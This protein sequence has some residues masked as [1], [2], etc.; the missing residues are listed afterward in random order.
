MTYRILPRVRVSRAI[1]RGRDGREPCGCFP[2]GS[3]L[4]AVRSAAP[5]THGRGENHKSPDLSQYC[6]VIKRQISSHHNSCF[7]RSGPLASRWIRI[8]LRAKK[9][10]AAVAVVLSKVPRRSPRCPFRRASPYYLPPSQAM[11]SSRP[12]G[13]RFSEY[14]P[15]DH[16][17]PLWIA[18]SITL[19]YAGLFLIVRLAVKWRLWSL[20]DVFLGVAHV[21]SAC[22]LHVSSDQIEANGRVGIRHCAMGHYFCSPRRRCWQACS[23]HGT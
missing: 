2:D 21:G 18:A 8:I 19:T 6:S 11:S 13:S 22:F 4:D 20:D 7:C 10:A 12:E 23:R 17:A 3:L 5:Q 15:T 16:Q 9:Q 1:S 14:T